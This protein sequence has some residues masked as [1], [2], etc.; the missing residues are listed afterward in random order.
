MTYE[1]ARRLAEAVVPFVPKG[2]IFEQYVDYI[3]KFFRGDL[4]VSISVSTGV[5]VIKILADAIPWTVLI[6]ATALIVSF[7][8]GIVIGMVMAYRRGGKFDSAMITFFSILRSMPEYIVAIVYLS[9]LGFQM[10][11]IPC[12]W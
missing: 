6:I 7:G 3:L 8:L 1:E 9:L 4:G 5:P 12:T 11:N 2:S 10:K